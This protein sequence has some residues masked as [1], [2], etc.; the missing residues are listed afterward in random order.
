MEEQRIYPVG[1]S[2]AELTQEA[3]ELSR[4]IAA[5][6]PRAGN[7]ADLVKDSVLFSVAY[8]ELHNRQTHRAARLTAWLVGLSAAVALAALLAAWLAYQSTREMRELQDRQR[9]L[10]DDMPRSASR[11][12]EAPSPKAAPGKPPAA[13]GPAPAPK[14]SAAGSPAQEPPQPIYQGDR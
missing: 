13:R 1:Y 5:H 11:P 12:R 4:R 10:L 6:D 8:I 7:G 14:K 3:A 2:D 9:L